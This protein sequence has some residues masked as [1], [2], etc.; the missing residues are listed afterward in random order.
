MIRT[1]DDDISKGR[2][3]KTFIDNRAKQAEN[4]VNEH[5]NTIQNTFERDKFVRENR[6]KLNKYKETMTNSISVDKGVIRRFDTKKIAEQE[7]Q[8][9]FKKSNTENKEEEA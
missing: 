4:N 6:A 8:F 5:A 3:T 1:L 7:K 2:G 9:D